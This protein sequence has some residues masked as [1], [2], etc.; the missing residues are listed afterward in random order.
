[1]S[2]YLVVSFLEKNPPS[3]FQKSHWP[4]HATIVR[5]FSSSKTAEEIIDALKILSKQTNQLRTVG[6]SREM[7][8]PE[9][10]IS[11]TELEKTPELQIFHEKTLEA[12]GP[13]NFTSFEYPDFRPHVSDHAAGTIAPGEEVI[14]HSLSLVEVFTEERKILY[15]G[16]LDK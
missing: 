5:P 9:N 3:V 13:I 2:S 15:T 6:K 1:M 16:E 14:F 4:L 10:D 12:I 7:F 11:V 8:G